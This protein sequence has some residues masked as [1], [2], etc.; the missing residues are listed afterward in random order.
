MVKSK[1][2]ILF[3]LVVP[4]LQSLRQNARFSEGHGFSRAVTR[5]NPTRL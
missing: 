5:E 2:L 1:S 4:D 3:S